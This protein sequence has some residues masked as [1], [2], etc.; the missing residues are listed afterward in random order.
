MDDKR[1]RDV[2]NVLRNLYRLIKSTDT[3]PTGKRNP[4]VVVAGMAD[5]DAL[6]NFDA[7][8]CDMVGVYIYPAHGNVFRHTY[9]AE[10][11]APM[12]PIIAKRSPDTPVMGIFQAFTGKTWAPRPT[13]LQVRKQARDFACFGASALMV[14]SWR[15]VAG[16]QTLRDMPD[17]REEVGRII[18]DLRSGRIALD[19]S[20]PQP[21]A[22]RLPAPALSQFT[23][24][25]TFKGA[26][27]LPGKTREGLAVHCAPGPDGSTWLHMDF[28]QYVQGRQE[29][30]GIPLTLPS[31]KEG[32]EAAASGWL[33]AKVHNFLPG[34]SEVGISVRDSRGR[35]FWAHY[36]P[37]A[38][39]RTTNVCVPLANVRRIVDL[40]DLA[41]VTV[42]MRRPAG[43]THLAL[44]GLYLAPRQF[45]RAAGFTFACPRTATL[46]AIGGGAADPAWNRVEPLLLQ[47]ELL[48]A[49]PL[50]RSSV[51]VMSS[52][53][54]IF[55]QV[56]SEGIAPYGLV[57]GAE[58]NAQWSLTDDTV[59]CLVQ[60]PKTGDFLR[61]IV[62]PNGRSAVSTT[63][64]DGRRGPPVQT[65]IASVVDPE[66]WRLEAAVDLADLGGDVEEWG[67]NLRRN[68][69][70]IG[71]L[72]WAKDPTLPEGVDA[73]GTL[74][75]MD[76]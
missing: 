28:A 43:P 71:P 18:Q 41:G 32:P 3:D 64:A 53:Q 76:R 40:S 35:P 44:E 60:N 15:M 25:L 13:P 52:G 8:V 16:S 68:D 70:Q 74:R 69:A 66:K 63:R 67:F 61:L 75:L 51:R 73:L 11:L 7:G 65:R 5:E 17:L 55:L 26:S 59:E 47:D 36:F 54:T 27:A 24:V 39:G 37:L 6:T 19:Q 62:N 57:V 72:V 46:P 48:N 22:R 23:P 33:V 1:G 45:A 38:A 20:W 12:L 9:I 50:R 49:P 4:H 42:F 2:R 29:W 56:V 30:P 14:Y 31:A 58:S 21:P 34:E 10:R